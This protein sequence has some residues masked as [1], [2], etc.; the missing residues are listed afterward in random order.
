MTGSG[1]ARLL[2]AILLVRRLFGRRS[3]RIPAREKDF[4]RYVLE[5]GVPSIE[6]PPLPEPGPWKG[7]EYI[8]EGFEEAS[9]VL[10][11]PEILLHLLLSS[12][13]DRVVT[14]RGDGLEALK[15][16][17]DTSREYTTPVYVHARLETADLRILAYEG[18]VTGLVIE[19]AAGDKLVAGRA[20]EVLQSQYLDSIPATVFRV[21]REWMKWSDE[22]L[23]VFIKGLD[24]QHKYLV[25]TLNH[26]YL[27]IV[28]GLG[29]KAL[30]EAL[31]RMVDYTKFH[32]RSEE[33]LMDKYNYP[34]D[35][36]EKHVREHNA[37]VNKVTEFREKYE[38]G[39]A[40]LTIDVIRFLAT[41]VETHI[42]RTDRDYGYYF[43]KIGLA[44]AA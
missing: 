18:K 40:K 34:R 9:L 17:A 21:K 29:E 22:K 8:A 28:G 3:G 7:I 14:L 19:R 30:R 32:F 43:K 39:E 23:S 42:A 37:F 35:K 36:F 41:W 15:I 25:A 2:R 16:V 13:I 12:S 26:L 20:L 33:V 27:G 24:R 38:A 11:D 4:I 31:R 6:P 5:V 10:L 1:L 44:T